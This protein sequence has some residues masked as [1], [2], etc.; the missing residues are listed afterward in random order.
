MAKK[1]KF[2]SANASRGGKGGRPQYVKKGSGVHN[3]T[4][5][6]VP[7]AGKNG[8][9]L[10]G[11]SK[12]K[13]AKGG[14]ASRKKIAAGVATAGLA[15]GLGAVAYNR[16]RSGGGVSRSAGSPS[17]S[18]PYY[19]N[20]SGFLGMGAPSASV[21]HHPVQHTGPTIPATG[22]KSNIPKPM[23][24]KGSAI[25]PGQFKRTPPGQATA[26]PTP[27]KS[28]RQSQE[29][30][31]EPSLYVPVNKRGVPYKNDAAVNKY[32]GQFK[33]LKA[34][35]Y[36]KPMAGAMPG[37]AKGA[38][39]NDPIETPTGHSGGVSHVRDSSG[40]TAPKAAGTRRQQARRSILNDPRAMDLVPTTYGDTYSDVHSKKAFYTAQMAA[41][42]NVRVAKDGSGA[43][44][45]RTTNAALH[46]KLKE[47]GLSQIG[48][49][50]SAKE[51]EL[52]GKQVA[53]AIKA[54]KKA[55]EAEAMVA[56]RR[57][58]ASAAMRQLK[59]AD[60][61]GDPVLDVAMIA[62]DKGKATTEQRRALRRA[63][64]I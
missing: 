47:A 53:K 5:G 17:A 2:Y 22:R 48:D 51:R 42:D 33:A 20:P 32:W 12:A 18:K 41:A 4:S 21:G 7:G 40:P 28:F 50:Q 16:S 36:G 10:P 63:G 59:D 44:T 8:G 14:Q 6:Y 55:A 11:G 13:T 29:F 19:R 25:A 15:I 64:L 31:I 9:A 37:K 61:E 34:D 45:Y 3:A 23:T 39:I 54:E 58:A 27:A 60:F 43:E 52:T 38:G 46:K 49:V 56:A 26:A 35:Q 24:I 1:K 30:A 62:F 57:A